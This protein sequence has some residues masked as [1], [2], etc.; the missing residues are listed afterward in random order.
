MPWPRYSP[1][2]TLTACGTPIRDCG[3]G[4]PQLR[5]YRWG[6][7]LPVRPDLGPTRR[8]AHRKAQGT[9]I[10]TANAALAKTTDAKM[11]GQPPPSGSSVQAKR[12]TPIAQS[13]SRLQPRRRAV[14]ARSRTPL[15]VWE[16]SGPAIGVR[17]W[18][19]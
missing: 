2:P 10:H 4:L 7:S 12:P 6:N 19:G 16:G 8:R 15:G 3:T 14:L 13:V 17:I 9:T 5:L 18:M 1:P 11:S